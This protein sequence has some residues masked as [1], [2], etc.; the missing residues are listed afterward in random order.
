M[1]AASPQGA[2][3]AGAMN[4]HERPRDEKDGRAVMVSKVNLEVVTDTEHVGVSAARNPTGCGR[5]DWPQS[6]GLG[7]SPRVYPPIC[8][9][10]KC[11]HPG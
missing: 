2:F 4:A 10:M 11:A 6:S 1:I 9:E 8:D 3:A 7:V 5:R